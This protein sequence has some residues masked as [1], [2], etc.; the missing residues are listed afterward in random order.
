[1]LV[2]TTRARARS[3]GM[4]DHAL[5][6]LLRPALERGARALRGWGVHADRVTWLGFAVGVSAALA[7]ALQAYIVG[8]IALLAS[9]L[10]D[11]LDGALARQTRATD[12]GAFLDIALDFLFYASIPLA[13]AV[14]DPAERALPAA[15]LLAAF[16]GT[17]S[18][19]LAY[20]VFAERRGLTSDAYPRKG[21]FYL[22]GLTE[23]TETLLCFVLMCLW[24]QH[25]AWWAYGFAAMCAVTVVTRIAAG[26]RVFGELEG[27][28][29]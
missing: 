18:S 14:A 22:G 17:G 28:Q 6:A 7:I 2:S 9:R 13:F 3:A 16:I 1:M 8:L 11:G 25:F 10:C 29:R 23:A 20:A 26:W 4:L 21:L 24:P 5:I 12:R 15:V 27:G 19:F